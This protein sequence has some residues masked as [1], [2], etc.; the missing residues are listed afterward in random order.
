MKSPVIQRII[1]LLIFTAAF[2]V[3]WLAAKAVEAYGWIPGLT[4]GLGGWWAI[5]EVFNR[6]TD[7]KD[8]EEKP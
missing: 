8:E 6:L 7:S 1:A 3:G 4:I 5:C 2:G